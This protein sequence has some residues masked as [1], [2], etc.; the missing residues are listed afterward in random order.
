MYFISA[1]KGNNEWWRYLLT[2]LV[3]FVVSQFVGAFPL[4]I[5]IAMNMINGK[6]ADLTEF[7][8]TYD[9]AALG[10]DNNTGLVV[11]LFPLVLMFFALLFMMV[12]FHGKKIGDIASAYGK[13]RWSRMLTA[14]MVW[15]V[16]L[17][18]GEII[19]ALIHPGSY[20]FQLELTKFLPLVLIAVCLV[21]FQAWSEELLFRSYLMQ[22]TGLLTKSRLAALL[23]TSLGFGLLHIANP[24]VREFGFWETMPYYVGFGMFAGIL[25]VMDNG[26]ELTFGVHAINNI[27][28]S[29]FVNYKSSALTT[30]SLWVNND[31]DPM[32]MNVGFLVMAIAFILIMNKL[33]K[34][35][36]WERFIKRIPSRN[37]VNQMK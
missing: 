34:W 36:N 25:V 13:I 18:I 15:L 31:P 9:P 32:L 1:Y 33:Y 35:D 12:K 8:R 4:L 11:M 3:I 21:P 24:E 6:P 17:V 27:Y 30:N 37:Q 16:L 5:I 7:S 14:A 20:T 26:I 23:I 2:L 22:G 29:T 19:F 28:S 10:I